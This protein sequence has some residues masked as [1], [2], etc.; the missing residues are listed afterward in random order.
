MVALD[1]WFIGPNKI[2]PAGA[3]RQNENLRG[4]QFAAQRQIFPLRGRLS[5]RILNRKVQVRYVLD[6]CDGALESPIKCEAIASD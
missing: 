1:S 3:F 4:K 5:D 6:G 2:G